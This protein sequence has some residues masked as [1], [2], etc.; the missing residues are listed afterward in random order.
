MSTT[1][2]EKYSKRIAVSESIYAREH[3]GAKMSTQRKTVIA[4]CLDNL[5]RYMNESF[6]AAS[7]TQRSDLGQWK[8]FCQIEA[9]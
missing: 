3:N 5:N 2:I 9:A 8:K 4:A 1:L 7:A 6:D